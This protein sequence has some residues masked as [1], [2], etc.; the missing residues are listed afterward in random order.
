M[1]QLETIKQQFH[2]LIDQVDDETVLARHLGEISV[3]VNIESKDFWDELSSKEQADILE[4]YEESKN[5]KNLIPNEV[6]KQRYAT[7]LTK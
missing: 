7:W 2:S 4:A 6:V 5:E 3:E 1:S